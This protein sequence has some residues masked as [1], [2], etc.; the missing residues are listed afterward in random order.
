M[1]TSFLLGVMLGIGAAFSVGP[2]FLMII[3]EA[4]THGF[5]SSFRIILGS[6]TADLLL[7]IPALSF[8]WLIAQVAQ[9]SLYVG[10]VG[11]IFLVY[12]SYEAA[13]NARRLW[14]GDTKLVVPSG[15]SF[16]KG[17]AGNL[18]NPLSWTFW[19]ATGT[20]T[21]LRSYHAAGA[22]GLVIFTLTWFVVA[23]SLEAL[24]AWIVVRSGRLV[25]ARAQ[26]LFNACAAVIFLVL[27]GLV[28]AQS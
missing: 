17:V 23:S 22:V 2:I 11:A 28:L 5:K 18:A 21:M 3:Q 24:I 14:R 19:L 7:L 16:W 26:A 12:L 25:G 1:Y 6:A 13:R 15:W 8:S 20:P 4:A 10:I 9:A 27:A